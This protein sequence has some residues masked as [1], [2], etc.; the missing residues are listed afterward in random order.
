[1]ASKSIR[2]GDRMLNRNNIEYEIESMVQCAQVVDYDITVK[3]EAVGL[4]T[5]SDVSI[6]INER[7][8]HSGNLVDGHHSFDCKITVQPKSEIEIIAKTSTHLHGK[9]LVINGLIINGVDIFETNLWVMDSQKFT[10][11]DGKVEQFNN[12]LYHNG[13]WSLNLPTPV[14]PWLRQGS[15]A[16][17]KTDYDHMHLDSNTD[18]YREILDKFFR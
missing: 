7:V 11:S 4:Q 13:V 5:G 8:I 12:G 14:L 3:V 2:S 9:R 1:M 6:S 18:E 16:K 15:V 10:H 17:S